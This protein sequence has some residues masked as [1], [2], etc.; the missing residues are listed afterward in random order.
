[1]IRILFAGDFD[2]EYNRTKILLKGLILLESVEVVLYTFRVKSFD[3]SRFVELEA[4]CDVIFSPSFSHATA[5]LILKLAV[6]PVVF[7]P[8]ISKYLTKV[9]DYKQVSKYGIRAYKNFRKDQLPM[10]NCSHLIADTHAHK[11][12]FHQTFKVPLSKISVLP[13]GVDCKEFKPEDGRTPK[14]KFVIGFYGGFIPLQGVA[15]ILQAAEELKSF[16]EIEFRL[17]GTGFEFDKMNQIVKDK[18]LSNVKFLGWIEADEL[19][20][21]IAD[22]DICLGIF[23]NTKKAQLVIPNK[24]FHYAAMAKPIITMKTSAVQE[25]FTNQNDIILIETKKGSLSTEII[26]QKENLLTAEAIG[27][28]ARKLVKSKY[29]EVGTARQ[30][31]KIIESIL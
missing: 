20:Q 14:E 27:K 9:F 7:D 15:Y 10:R 6:K 8:L 26:Q 22:F 16:T 5:N 24:I 18:N 25:L 29:D 30:F 19:P 13:V 28:N 2:P 1:M 3:K 23:G 21:V 4:G 31:I 17:V 11:E 12:Y